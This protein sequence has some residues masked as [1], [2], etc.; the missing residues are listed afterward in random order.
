MTIS[1]RFHVENEAALADAAAYL[2]NITAN[3]GLITLHGDLGAGK[4]ALTR[5]LIRHITRTPDADVPSP[6]YTLLQTYDTSALHI[7]H[8]DLYRLKSPDEIYELGWEDALAPHNLVIL[9]WPVRIAPL[10]PANRIDVAITIT[11]P[12]TRDI[13]V[14]HD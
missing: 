4:T 11:S 12:T 7:W 2:A 8:F 9:E 1:K 10:L 5:T 14:Q 13:T 6:T 3:G